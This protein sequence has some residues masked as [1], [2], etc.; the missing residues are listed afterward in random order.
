MKNTLAAAW[1]MG[2]GGAHS[3]DPS[4]SYHADPRERQGQ[5]GIGGSSMGDDMQLDAS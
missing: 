4:G 5:M 3:R 2:Y 1:R